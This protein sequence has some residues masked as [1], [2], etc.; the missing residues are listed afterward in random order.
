MQTQTDWWHTTVLALIQGLTEFLPVSSSAH[1][2]LP[3]ALFGWPDQGLAFDVAVHLGSLLAVLLYFRN[4][5]LGL[6]KG[7]LETVATGKLNPQTRQVLYLALATLPVLFA[8]FTFKSSIEAQLRGP[9]VI[10][11]STIVFGGLLLLA[12]RHSE[13]KPQATA[14]SWRV[15][16]IIGLAQVIALI[17]GTSRSGIT[18]TA[19]LFC[20]LE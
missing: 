4:E 11:I 3:S 20:G 1:L 9:L 15:A 14:I 13:V 10:A 8:G 19:A 18:M 16:L 5:L 6:S 17:P 12:D 2:I 7:C